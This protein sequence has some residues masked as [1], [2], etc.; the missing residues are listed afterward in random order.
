MVQ[1][2][3]A[4]FVRWHTTDGN[5]GPDIG[6]TVSLGEGRIL[7]LGTIPE[8][9]HDTTDPEIASLGGSPGSYWLVLEPGHTPVARFTN[10]HDAKLLAEML[11][12]S[13]MRPPARTAGE[14]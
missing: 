11:A 8:D 4:G 2:D 6:I 10:R 3:E 13:F 7:W 1:E 12:A 9:A 14:G 5:E